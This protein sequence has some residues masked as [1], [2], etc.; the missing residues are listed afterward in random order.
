MKLS[1]LF[2]VGALSALALTSCKSNDDN[3]EWLGSDGINF[4]SYIEGL[5]SR[6]SGSAWDDGDRVGIFMTAGADEF[7]NREYAASASG[8]L[9]PAGQA[10]K[11]PE[12]GSA[13]FLAYYPYTASLSGKT[14]AVD[15]T[16]Q[17]D[18][19]KIDLLYSNNAANVANGETVNLAFKH[20]L[21]QIVINVEKDAT[22]ETTAGLA[23]SISGMDTQASFDLNDGTL[24]P[25]GNKGN[26]AMNVNAEGTQAEA[27]VIPAADLSGAKMTFTLQGMSFDY[28]VTG[29]YEAGTKYTYKATL[30][31]LNGQPAVTMGTAS[32]EDWKDQAGGDINVD[33]EEGEAPSGEEFVALDAPFADGMDGFTI[34]DVE[35]GDVGYVWKHD[36]EYHYMKASA[37]VGDVDYATESWLISPAIDLTKATTAKLTFTHVIN[38]DKQG[39]KEQNQTL[40]VAD[41][42][43]VDAS[44]T[45]W[46]QVTITTYPNGMS[47]DESSSGDIDLSKY[48]GKTIKLG[49]KYV[50]T[51]SSAA[52]WEIW[53]VKV[54]GNPSGGTVDP[55]PDP[56]PS[57]SNLLTNPGFEDWTAAL[58]TAWDN[59]TYNTGEIVKETTIKHEGN[60]SLRQTSASGTNK[61]Q[62]E[63]N[64]IGGKKYRISYWFLDNDT[65]ASSR[66]WFAMVG[67]DGKTIN[68]I[69]DQIQQTDYST[70]NAEWQNVVIEFTAPEG[71]VKMRYEVRTYRNMDSNEAGGYIYY[72]D[73]ELT[74]VQ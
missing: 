13:S 23:I 24:T 30:S 66:Y 26:I 12:E 22:I 56:E 58:P 2:Y 49:F 29:T 63:V 55:D 54:V 25:G 4:T 48:A 7:A 67:S 69:N 14:Y 27:I 47:W 10:L 41:A 1:N 44:S 72:D 43:A 9:T 68:E 61:V 53:N 18:P 28:S 21:S 64:I 59:K 5:T 19:K 15:V 71:T 32:I 50:S 33:F 60:N 42:A 11:W 51:E 31:I 73:M 6:A 74:E 57:G 35:L 70:D 37:H 62:Q 45:G 36:A 34:D 38:Y 46:E 40:W 16:D 17:T 3:S 20:Q 39:E 52:T 8:N 65:K